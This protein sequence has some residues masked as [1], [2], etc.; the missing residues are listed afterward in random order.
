M[1]ITKITIKKTKGKIR[2]GLSLVVAPT[3]QV[4]NIFEFS[5]HAGD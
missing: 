1:Y 5:T 3:L 2:K 4:E